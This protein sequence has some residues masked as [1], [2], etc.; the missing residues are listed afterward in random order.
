MCVFSQAERL[1]ESQLVQQGPTRRLLATTVR[2][3]VRSRVFL[4]GYY[5]NAGGADFLLLDC[6]SVL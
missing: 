6:A 1:V 3:S 5:L 2:P 4:Y